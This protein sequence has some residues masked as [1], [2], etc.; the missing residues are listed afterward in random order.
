MIAKIL[1]LANDLGT[2]RTRNLHQEKSFRDHGAGA[3]ADEADEGLGVPAALVPSRSAAR[4]DR[5]AAA[6][7]EL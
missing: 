6:A 7:A 1:V 3:A 2:H 4:Y 5:P